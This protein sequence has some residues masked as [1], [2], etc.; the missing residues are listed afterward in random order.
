MSEAAGS[1]LLEIHDLSLDIGDRCLYKGLSLTLGQ[2][3]KIAITGKSGSGKSTLLKC[4]LGFVIPSSGSISYQG[5]ELDPRTVWPLRYSLGYVPQEADLGDLTAGEFIRR[6]FRY[7]I[8]RGLAWEDERL[9]ELCAAFHLEHGLLSQ[10]S[11]KLSGGEKQRVALIA[12]L[13]L[14][15]KLYLFDE[16]T[17][18]LDE[19]AR[20]AVIGYLVKAESFA[21]VIVAH[22]QEL[23]AACDRV[24][25]LDP[26]G[27]LRAFS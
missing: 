2:G 7:G 20:A 22:D 16:I 8:N 21:A 13:M 9:Q 15:R 24:Y 11:R 25:R 4:I 12:A 3:E 1:P 19:D 6:P 18:A 27:S 23:R 26:K 17:S 14:E 10:A 5:T